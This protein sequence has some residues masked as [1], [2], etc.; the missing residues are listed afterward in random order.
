[1][2]VR[3]AIALARLEIDVGAWTQG[4]ADSA[5]RVDAARAPQRRIVDVVIAAGGDEPDV[6]P[7]RIQQRT[8]AAAGMRHVAAVILPDDAAVQLPG[9]PVEIRAGGETGA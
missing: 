7:Q 1:R 3:P 4:P 9:Q 5:G 8:R 2:V 6:R